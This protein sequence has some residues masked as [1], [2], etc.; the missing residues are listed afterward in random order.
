M[1]AALP[2]GTSSSIA[3]TRNPF[4]RLCQASI[5]LGKIIRHHY[6]PLEPEIHQFQHASELYLEASTMARHL[7]KEAGASTDYLISM[8]PLA[9]C[10]SALSVLCDPYAC[11]MQ[12]QNP[13]NSA[14][15]SAM[16]V[17]ATEGIRSVSTSTREMAQQITAKTSHSL[18]IDRIS[19]LIFDSLYV[20]ASNFAWMVRENG[21]ES[22]AQSLEI[23]RHCLRRLGGRFGLSLSVLRILEAQ[24]FTYAVER[25]AC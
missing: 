18:D 25:P 7:I 8:T 5:L 19:P 16:K 12:R 14:D 6:H 23:L 22:C 20:A 1:V 2:L 17:Q 9:V 4:A 11:V 15:E 3:E 21:D 13:T 10:L 24:E